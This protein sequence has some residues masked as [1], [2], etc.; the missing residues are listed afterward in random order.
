LYSGFNPKFQSRKIIPHFLFALFNR[1][2]L[3]KKKRAF[4]FLLE[5]TLENQKKEEARFFDFLKLLSVLIFDK[6]FRAQ[7]GSGKVLGF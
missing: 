6:T 7:T 2:N 3:Q 1:I 5:T 4:P